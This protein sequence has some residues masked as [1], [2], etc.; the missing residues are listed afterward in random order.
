MAKLDNVKRVVKE[1][2][3]AKYHGLID[4]L[5]FVLNSFMEQVTNEVNG[6]LD[7]A[8]LKQDAVTVK[9]TVNA[10]GVP[11]GSGLLRTAVASPTGFQVIKV[12]NV[13]NP[14]TVFAT[15]QPFISFTS[16]TSSGVVKIINIS[17]LPA[18]T[19][20]NLTIVAIG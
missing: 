4:K 5:A 16:G 3:E 14:T 20:F 1:D 6:N 17:G 13:D 19:A 8:N 12:V 2:Y 9:F 11:D 7:F 10:S 18:N 15:T